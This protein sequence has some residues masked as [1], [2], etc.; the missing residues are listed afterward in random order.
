MKKFCKFITLLLSFLFVVSGFTGC[1]AGNITVKINDANVQTIVE[2]PISSTVEQA[3]KEAELELGEKDEVTPSADTVLKSGDEILLK[4][5]VN[6]SVSR[7]G[8]V[9]K[10]SLVGGKVSD[11]LDKANIRLENNE[12][13]NFDTDTYLTDGMEIVID[14]C[15]IVHFTADGKTEDIRTSV[16][17]VEEF[18][19]G[20]GV[21]VGGDDI[22]S[23]PLKEAIDSDGELSVKRVTHK[24]VTE[25]ED[26]KYET[27]YKT[28]SSM[29]TGTST[30]S[31][32]GENGQKTVKY[33]ITYIDGK[34]SERKVIEE[35][36][37]TEPIDEIVLRG[38]K[39]KVADNGGKTV[40]SKQK[41][42]NCNGDGHGYYI[43][44]WSDG[45]VTYEEY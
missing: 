19:D 45:T 26:I 16:C 7:N 34:E 25:T 37:I 12:I 28:S 24:N 32:K 6:V 40:K 14:K 23:K 31:R 30:V 41:V 35:K 33:D 8:N 3:I 20:Q 18:L 15:V 11:V 43:V 42:E 1:K 29:K 22:V 10:L 36:I 44:T 39:K 13:V 21:E 2:I 27:V 17:T 38:P 4:R 5:Y 9:Q